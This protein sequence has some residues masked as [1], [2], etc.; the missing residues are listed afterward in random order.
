MLNAKCSGFNMKLSDKNYED[1]KLTGKKKKRHSI[2]A[3]TEMTEMLELYEELKA[4]IINFT[5]HL[6]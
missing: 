3:N 1:L 5:R 2:D 6:Q 4:V